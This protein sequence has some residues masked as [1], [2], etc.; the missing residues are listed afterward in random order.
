MKVITEQNLVNKLKEQ[1]KIVQKELNIL[2][3]CVREC[4]NAHIVLKFSNDIGTDYG[5]LATELELISAY[6]GTSLK[7]G[8]K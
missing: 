1:I 5:E 8:E 3:N 2:E 4:K 6:V 7:L